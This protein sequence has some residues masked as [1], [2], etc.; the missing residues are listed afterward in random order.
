MKKLFNIV[1]IVLGI[2]FFQSCADNNPLGFN[3]NESD[4]LASMEY[5]KNYDVLKSYVDRSATPNFKLGSAVEATDFINNYIVNNLTKTNFDEI[6]AGN[7]MKYASCVGNDGS[8]NF[9]T[10]KSFIESAQ[11]AGIS[12]YGHT[13]AWHSQQNNKYLNNVIADSL[14]PADP[15][16]NRMLHINVPTA[17]TNPWDWELYY[18]L[19]IPLVI[20]KNYVISFDAKAS[21]DYVMPFWPG[22]GSSTQYLPSFNISTE[23]QTVSQSFTANKA[24]N[25]MR[26]ELGNFAGDLY[27]DNFSIKESGST[28]NLASNSTFDSDNISEWTKSS[29]LVCELLGEA[30]KAIPFTAEQKKVRLTNC[31][32]QWIEGMMKACAGNVT[33]WDVVNEPMSGKDNDGDGYYDL[34]SATRGVV[35]ADD[36]KNNFYWQDYLGDIDYVRTAVSLARKHFAANGGDASKLKLFIN[37]Y[38]LESDWDGN[39]KLKS[40]IHWISKWEADGVTK[41]DGIGTQMHISSYD[42]DNV[43]ESKKAHIVDM[44]KLMAAT[45]KLVRISELDM[46]IVDSTGAAVLTSNATAKELLRQKDLYEF[47]VKAYFDNVPAAQRY[48]ICQWCQT[49]SPST[50]SWLKNQPVGLWTLDYA[51][52]HAYAGFAD[53]LASSKNK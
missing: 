53:G 44:F 20:G 6:T 5:L 35:S 12:V 4:S 7:A 27:I 21:S 11:K 41:I 43:Q 49:D 8:M 38:N 31:M 24:M 36:A 13:L 46:C 26:F 3:V 23:K 37:D 9:S 42:N 1:P 48:G 29:G 30:S 39:M 18:N 47:V 15:N 52:K 50:S 45:G 14:P 2:M 28:E 33:S 34:Q 19:S 51:R 25:R 16:A 17:K 32:S 40:L 10:V 22:D